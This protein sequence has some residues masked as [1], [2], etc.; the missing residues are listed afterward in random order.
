MDN[1][2]LSY[3][4]VEKQ[5]FNTC[6][7][8]LISHDVPFVNLIII[9]LHMKTNISIQIN[10]ILHLFGYASIPN[11]LKWNVRKIVLIGKNRTSPELKTHVRYCFICRTSVT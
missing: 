6:F 4:N 1:K 8:S 5:F 9:V 10:I 7:I 3:I 11:Q 2:I